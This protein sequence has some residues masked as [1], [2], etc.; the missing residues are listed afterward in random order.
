MERLPLVSQLLVG[1]QEFKPHCEVMV[2]VVL[3]I[4]VLPLDT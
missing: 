2:S 1:E 4:A 3:N